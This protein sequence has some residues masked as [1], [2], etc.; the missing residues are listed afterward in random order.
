MASIL[1]LAEL[2]DAAYGGNIPAVWHLVKKS[3]PSTNGYVGLAFQNDAGEIVIANKGTDSRKDVPT[4]LMLGLHISTGAQRDAATFAAQVAA[5]FSNQPIIETGHSLGGSEA[6]SATVAL[7]ILGVPVSA[8]TFNS[9]GIGG[10]TVPAGNYNVLNLYGQG[11][12]IHTTGGEHLGHSQVLAAGPDTA[13]IFVHDLQ[14]AVS[15]RAFGLAGVI[16]GVGVAIGKAAYNII[17]P[18]HIIKTVIDFLN[19]GGPGES[20]GQKN[21]GQMGLDTPL[22]PLPTPSLSTQFSDG[23][24]GLTDTKNNKATVAL[25][26]DGAIKSANWSSGNGETGTYDASAE[27]ANLVWT[28][29]DGSATVFA[30]TADGYVETTTAVDGTET[31]QWEKAD[32]SS[33]STTFN[34]DGAGRG[35]T[36]AVNG[37]NTTTSYGAGKIVTQTTTENVDGSENNTCFFSDGSIQLQSTINADGS[38]ITR[39]SFYYETGNFHTELIR[40]VDGSESAAAYSDNGSK[41]RSVIINADGSNTATSYFSNGNISIVRITNADGSVSASYYDPNDT[42]WGT[43][44]TG[45][46]GVTVHT[47]Y[48]DAGNG[49]WTEQHWSTSISLTN[50][51]EYGSG[52]VTTTFYGNGSP[53]RMVETSSDGSTRTYDYFPNGGTS[54]IIYTGLDGRKIVTNYVSPMGSL[55]GWRG[56]SSEVETDPDGTV[57][58]TKMYA[59]GE[60]SSRIVSSSNGEVSTQ[61]FYGNG[62]SLSDESDVN[63]GGEV[64]SSKS[65]SF[66]FFAQKTFEGWKH[67]DGSYGS[68]IINVVDGSSTSAAN[69][70]DGSSLSVANNAD[71]SSRHISVDKAG[72]V[73]TMNYDAYGVETSD[74]WVHVDGSISYDNF[75]ADG[76]S[77]D[78]APTPDGSGTVITFDGIGGTTYTNYGAGGVKLSD[79]WTKADGSSGSDIFNADGSSSSTLLW[80]DGTYST[81]ID[82]AHGSLFTTNYDASNF[83][84]SDMWTKADGASGVDTFNVDG[85]SYGINNNPDGSYSRYTNDGN[86][87]TSTTNYA[88]DGSSSGVNHNQDGSFTTIV[89]DTNGNTTTVDYDASWTKSSDSWTKADGSSGIDTFNMDGS[90]SGTSNS[91]DGSHSSYTNDGN[92][93]IVTKNY[94]ANGIELGFSIANVDGNGNTI[95]QNYDVSGVEL[96]YSVSIDNLHGNS[97][98]L[99][100]TNY[101]TNGLKLSD[102][103]TK[104]DGS[105]GTDIFNLDESSSGTGIN[106]DGSYSNYVNDGQGNVITQYFGA[107]GYLNGEAWT[108]ADGSRGSDIY[109]VDGSNSRTT[110]SLDGSYSTTF[111][112]TN[113]GQIFVNYSAAGSKLNDTWTKIDGTFGNDTFNA[114]GTST[115]RDQTSDGSYNLYTGDGLGTVFITNFDATGAQLGHSVAI[116]DAENTT[117]TT[118]YGI[119]NNELGYAI[120]T[121]DGSGD[122]FTTDYDVSGKSIGDSW[123]QPGG[124]YGSDIFKAD[125]TTENKV[126]RPLKFGGTHSTDTINALDGS[127]QQTWSSSNGS[128][129]SVSYNA[130]TGEEIGTDV[131]PAGDYTSTYDSTQNT[132]GVI[133]A[134]EIKTVYAFTDGSWQTNDIFTNPDFSQIRS[135]SLSDG[136]VGS[137]ETNSSGAMV[138]SSWAQANGDQGVDA[139]VNHL[140]IAGSANESLAAT[141][142]NTILIGAGGNDSLTTGNGNNIIAFNSGNGQEVV[143]AAA[144]QNN[145]VSLGGTFAYADLALQ[146][147][148]S[149]LVLDVGSEGITFKNWYAGSA[150]VAVL[151]IVTSAMSDYSPGSGSALSGAQV[152]TFDFQGLVQAF[153]Q[154]RSANPGISAWSVSDALLNV[155]LSASDSAAIGGDLTFEYGARGSLAGMSVAS[156]QTTMTG[157][158]FA[159]NAQSFSS[160]SSVHSGAAQLK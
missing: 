62:Y 29:D 155:H 148:G 124:V 135:W 160:W 3:D 13:K 154:V 2:S 17:R 89:S 134:S 130:V 125:G 68:D 10:Y 99:T 1:E 76:F 94:D 51:V 129:G 120:S 57:T 31:G 41:L 100:I 61:N 108:Q 23:T 144:G 121:N 75:F 65:T 18:A 64:G 143:D 15:A 36:I 63:I 88:I 7:T 116:T 26:D 136:S 50:H 20:L 106:Q 96:G 109:N 67:S 111:N 28:N 40:N 43:L 117:T 34:S 14:N 139:G 85:T 93:T 87:A 103:W 107:Y 42:S 21:W 122:V 55:M 113:G 97:G 33:G 112:D 74:S 54:S 146:K 123:S 101:E 92:G 145:T 52:S 12:L 90:S 8:V 104:I 110:Y 24:L 69:Y 73:I 115:G 119:N 127:Y 126:T 131:E 159:A 48:H 46:D 66:N 44:I 59:N 84:L 133:G 45:T 6:Q 35:F 132:G 142:G 82:D 78:I 114:D 147:N 5:K 157:S 27:T 150:N 149:D 102:S 98:L 9:P 151:Q 86:G 56:I 4:D 49:S 71:G 37:S 105:T 141:S 79:N 22:P 140:L 95:T 152:E 138:G 156:A 25:G 81:T 77:G 153:D 137:M 118:K 38:G 47:S 11:D 30:A 32:G 58:T 80:P 53:A 70:A 16:A 39:E 60:V 91:L 72:N 128:Y 158:G 19:V 83:K